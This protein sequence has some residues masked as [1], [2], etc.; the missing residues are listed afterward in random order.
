MMLAIFNYDFDQVGQ[1]VGDWASAYIIQRINEFKPTAAR[2]FVLGLP[3]G[4]AAI[5]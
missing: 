1:N 2:P 3:T 5:E 4:P